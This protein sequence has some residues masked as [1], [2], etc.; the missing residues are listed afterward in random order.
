MLEIPDFSPAIKGVLWENWISNKGVF[1]AYEEDKVYTYAF[2]KDTIQ[3]KT[4]KQ[5]VFLSLI[6]MGIV[7]LVS[8]SCKDYGYFLWFW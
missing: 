4:K 2:H 8:S 5:N 3:G 7:I 6:G 1:V